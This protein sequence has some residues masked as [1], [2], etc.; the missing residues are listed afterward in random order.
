MMVPCIPVPPPGEILAKLFPNGAVNPQS[1]GSAWTA[2]LLLT[3]FGGTKVSEISP[4]D[5]VVVGNLT[6]DASDP[7]ELYMR[8]GLYLL[9]GLQYYDFLFRTSHAGTQWWCLTS[10][11]SDPNSLPTASF[12]PFTAGSTV[13]PPDFLTINHFSHAGG[14]NVLGKPREAFSGRKAAKSGTWYWFDRGS[15]NI[16]RIMNVEN[17][18]DFKVPVLGAYYLVDVPTF[19]GRALSNLKDVYEACRQAAKQVAT[20]SPMLT[21]SD[22]L[23]AM[24]ETPVDAQIKCTLDHIQALLPGIVKPT[25]VVVPPSWTNKVTSE[26]LMIGQDLFPYYCQV[27]YDWDRGVQVTV[28]VQRNTS[29]EYSGRFDELLPKGVVGPAI[30]YSWSGSEWAAT[31]CQAGASV[32]SMPVPDF[33]KAGGGKCR[34]TIL[35]NPYFGNL[36]IWSVEL[37]GRNNNSSNFWYWFN[38]QQQGVIFSLAPAGSLTI[39]D[40]QTFIQNKSMED[41]IFEN[42]CNDLPPCT[43]EKASARTKLRFLGS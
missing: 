18:N 34:A 29:G 3:P 14:W 2:Q 40:Y 15:G 33:V 28:F 7:A 39:I 5:Q 20:P 6:Y 9:E 12:G 19:S 30:A 22:L 1:L 37:G 8:F 35:N 31:C 38:D 16:A 36:T 24:A 26:C 42:P 23:R 4:N 11:P 10:D 13:P 27:W 43:P 17:S 21:L 25:E 41:C 32:V